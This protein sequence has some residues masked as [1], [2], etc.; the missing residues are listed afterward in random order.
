[1]GRVRYL[2]FYLLCG[3]AAALTQAFLEPAAAQ[4]R[5]WA[6]RVRSAG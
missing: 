1:M 5:W 6:R 2:V 4:C 3:L